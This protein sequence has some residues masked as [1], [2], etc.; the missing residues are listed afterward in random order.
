MN[1][2]GLTGTNDW[3]EFS[4]KLHFSENVQFIYVDMLL[5]GEGTVWIDGISVQN[6]D[7]G[8]AGVYKKVKKSY[9][10]SLVTT[11]D[12]GVGLTIQ[13]SDSLIMHTGIM[14]K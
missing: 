13:K 1:D 8:L 9:T 11:F 6:D 3:K 12:N 2:R 7:K 10:A 5:V 4:I 14:Q